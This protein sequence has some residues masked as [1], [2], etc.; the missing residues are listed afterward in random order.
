MVHWLLKTEPEEI[1]GD[2]CVK[3]GAK[4]E[5]WTGVRNFTA[6]SHMKAIKKGD[7]I[8]FYHTGDERQIV[9]LAEV[10]REAYPDPTDEKGVF[11]A[12]DVKALSPLPKPVM[13]AA[14]K[15]APRLKEMA[16][17]KY[18]RLSVQ[19]VTASEWS[20]S[21]PYGRLQ[22]IAAAVTDQPPPQPACRTIGWMD[23]RPGAG[24]MKN[25][26]CHRHRGRGRLAGWRGLVHGARQA[27]DGG[28]GTYAGRGDGSEVC[29]GRIPA[30]H[31]FVRGRAG[32]G[33]DAG[34]RSGASWS[35]HSAHDPQ[36]RHHRRVLLVRI[37]DHHHAGQQQ[38]LARREWRLLWIDGG[39]WLIV[40]VL[41]GA[42]I[43]AIGL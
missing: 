2:D 31:L 26:R 8:L 19:P 18:S 30:V 40:L 6:R 12:V 37:C 16:L 23:V 10:I 21:L 5:P 33:L 27:L 11:V 22:G 14:I 32:D 1:P 36:R 28:A 39:H 43:G 13:L 41:M 24:L 17:V 29:S 35:A 4:G 9:G 3:R 34:R 20:L 15:A 25:S 38:L 7:Q 42:V